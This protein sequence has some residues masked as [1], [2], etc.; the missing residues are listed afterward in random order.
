M[1]AYERVGVYTAVETPTV[2][3]C[4]QAD[5]AVA[6]PAH[7]PLRPPHCPH[8]GQLAGSVGFPTC[9]I[10]PAPRRGALSSSTCLRTSPIEHPIPQ[11]F[12]L[13]AG[14]AVGRFDGLLLDEVQV[15]V[16]VAPRMTQHQSLLASTNYL[17]LFPLHLVCLRVLRTILVCIAPVLGPSLLW[18]FLVLHAVQLGVAVLHRAEELGE[19]WSGV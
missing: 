17:S 8:S 3:A 18:I 6:T 19:D 12:Q 11:S 5:S 4:S 10:S 13:P 14:E 15:A 16:C 1:P 7:Y 9:S 2:C